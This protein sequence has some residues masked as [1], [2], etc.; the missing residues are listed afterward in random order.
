MADSDKEVDGVVLAVPVEGISVLDYDTVVVD[1]EET[2]RAAVAAVG[3]EVSEEVGWARFV[4]RTAALQ[5]VTAAK[6]RYEAERSHGK[7]HNDSTAHEAETQ[8]SVKPDTYH[9]ETERPVVFV[10]FVGK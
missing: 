3:I 7:V 5:A 4:A 2:K 8:Q 6:T 1:T 9:P 10:G